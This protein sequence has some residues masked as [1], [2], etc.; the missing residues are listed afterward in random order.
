MFSDNSKLQKRT[1]EELTAAAATQTDRE[2]LDMI[3]EQLLAALEERERVQLMEHN[4]S[5]S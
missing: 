2:E 3:L 4:P 5:P 1:W